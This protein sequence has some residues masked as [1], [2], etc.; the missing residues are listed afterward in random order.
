M[1]ASLDKGC[2]RYFSAV[3][4]HSNGEELSNDFAL[5]M[6]HALNKYK[7]L[8]NTLPTRIIVYRDGVGEGQIP[9][10][11]DHEVKQ[12]NEKLSGFYEGSGVPLKLAF[13]IVTKRINTRFFKGDWNPAPG[14][15]VDDVVTNPAR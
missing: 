7:E 1:V 15:V 8:N 4:A 6:I 11:Y 10:V 12:L 14:T 9:Y 3:S 5:N 13:I 2:T